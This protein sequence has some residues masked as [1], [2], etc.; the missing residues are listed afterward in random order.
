MPPHLQ[1]K[2]N[3]ELDN[4]KDITKLDKVGEKFLPETTSRQKQFYI[5]K[6]IDMEINFVQRTGIKNVTERIISK[7]TNKKNYTYI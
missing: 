7:Q 3:L 2:I 1:E 4:K 5:L 6:E